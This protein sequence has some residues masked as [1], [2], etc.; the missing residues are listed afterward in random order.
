[1]VI[2]RTA[3]YT[4]AYARAELVKMQVQ[5]VLARS[6][7]DRDFV[8]RLL[9][10]VD[11]RWISEISVYGLDGAGACHVE[12]FIRIDWDRNALHIAAGRDTVQVD[13]GWQDGVSTEID[14]A[15][16][17]FELVTRELGLRRVVH[18]RYAPGVDRA[19]ANRELGFR[20]ANP[21]QW[22]SGFYGTTM[23][24]PELDEVTVGVNLAG[25]G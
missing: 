3:T 21:V 20:T 5:R 25:Q 7:Q 14:L 9:I 6:S 24:I 18:S 23:S 1:M 4:A 17:K 8:R 19:R 11:R 12:L 15:L 10:G 2:A 16:Q 13:A 22:R